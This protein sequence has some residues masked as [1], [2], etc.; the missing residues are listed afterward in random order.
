MS[1]T[2]PPAPCSKRVG[3][4]QSNYIPWKGYFD[5]IARC[6]E[7]VFL[8]DA[9]FTKRDWRNRNQVKTSAGRVW[10][11]VPVRSKGRFTQ[12]IDET[13]ISEP[14]AEKHW[15]TIAHEYARAAAFAEAAPSLQRLFESVRSEPNLSVLNRRITAELCASLGITTVLRSSRDYGS[16]GTRSDR[17]IHLCRAARATTYLSGPA[18]RAYLDEAQF[19]AAGIA[20]EW[21]DYTGYP[22]YAQPHPPFE[23][24]VSIV[25]TILCTGAL[26]PAFVRRSA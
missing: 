21:M 8:D 20:V 19:A 14:W 23:H 22:E 13:E 11:T 9:Q 7:F 4:I 1:A 18:A 25:D 5:F 3:I 2:C 24:G 26:A 15:A 10:L 17:L 6:D 16:C 12:A